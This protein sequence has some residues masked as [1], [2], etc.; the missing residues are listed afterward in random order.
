[1]L[2]RSI[3]VYVEPSGY[4][5]QSQSTT[6][7]YIGK[8]NWANQTSQYELKDESFNGKIF[9]FRMYNKI[10]GTDKIEKTIAW[11]KDNLGIK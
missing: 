4:L 5:P 10:M 11:G 6:N 1:M 8:S 2:F 3:Q 9:D 7:N